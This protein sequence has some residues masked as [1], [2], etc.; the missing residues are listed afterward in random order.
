MKNRN[1]VAAGHGQP[2]DG[3][4]YAEDGPLALAH[5]QGVEIGRASREAEIV[6]WLRH[7]DSG[8][9]GDGSWLDSRPRKVLSDLID[10]GAGSRNQK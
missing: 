10:K 5:R 2:G 3:G 9:M 7:P 8:D 4:G 6:A 1:A